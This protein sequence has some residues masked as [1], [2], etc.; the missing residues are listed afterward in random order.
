MSFHFNLK[1]SV[2]WGSSFAMLGAHLPPLQVLPSVSQPSPPACGSLELSQGKG[3]YGWGPAQAFVDLM[4]HAAP[5]ACLWPSRLPG[6]CQVF[7]KL[8][9]SFSRFSLEDFYLA[10]VLFVCFASTAIQWL[11]EL[12]KKK[13]WNTPV[14]LNSTQSEN[15]FSSHSF[16]VRTPLFPCETFMTCTY[17]SS[18]HFAGQE[19][20]GGRKTSVDAVCPAHDAPGLYLF[21]L[22]T[23]LLSISRTSKN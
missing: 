17:S 21:L 8:P 1:D 13:K 20:P 15:A 7:P 18:W 14:V 2:C 22:A 9:V 10:H 11:K 12:K 19:T 23:S 5:P 3:V 6:T 16:F 4:H